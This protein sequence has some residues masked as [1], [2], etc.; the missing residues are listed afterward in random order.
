MS[1]IPASV[2]PA[3]TAFENVARNRYS[4]TSEKARNTRT[5]KKRLD[6]LEKRSR[7]WSIILTLLATGSIAAASYY[8]GGPLS[9]KLVSIGK[10]AAETIRA[11]GTA[12]GTALKKKAEFYTKAR[13]NEVSPRTHHFLPK[14]ALR[15]LSFKSVHS[16]GTSVTPIG[17]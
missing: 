4:P 7:R 13:E 11:S 5:L 9:A 1:P 17:K 14:A 2:K 6:V 8:Y 15:Q 12:D 3:L 10:T 16:K